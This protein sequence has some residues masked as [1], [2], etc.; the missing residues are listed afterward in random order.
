MLDGTRYYL[1]NSAD[2]VV[3]GHGPYDLQDPDWYFANR[4]A[5]LHSELGIVSVPVVESMR[6]MMP[7][8]NLWPIN[9]MWAVHDY[10]TPRMPLYTRRIVRRYGA[11]TGIEDYC[12]KAQMVN[13]ESAKAMYESL[14]SRQG[15]GILVWMTQ[16]AWP[17]LICQLYDYYFEPTAAFYGAK[18]ACEPIHILWDQESDRIKVANDTV[19]DRP[20]LDVDAATYDLRGVELWHASSRILAPCQAARDCFALP[21][22]ADPGEV[23][24]VKLRLLDRGALVSENFYWSA[25]KGRPCTALGTLPVAKVSSS[26]VRIPGGDGTVL[27]VTSHNSADSVA[28]MLRLRVVRASSG[29]RVL[30][31]F[32]DDNFF[33]LLPGES[34]EVEVRIP[35]SALGGE[36][37]ELIQEGWNVPETEIPITVC[38]DRI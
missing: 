21:R 31:A 18:T 22:P 3:T 38:K 6:E 23:F 20:D 25:G 2:G 28:V 8:G 5:T 11:L 1:P 7:A 29:K 37:P 36:E 27:R 19:A 10:Q 15:S 14:Q 17:S 12:R 24:F 16:S 33:S 13:L 26:A 30:P 35:A 34:K 32:F 9:Q 4:G